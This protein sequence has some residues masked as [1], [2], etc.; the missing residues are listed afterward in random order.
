MRR[1][2]EGY[3]TAQEADTYANRTKVM[4]EA[5]LQGEIKSLI[6]GDP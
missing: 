4:E 5:A 3:M 1:D 6:Q 2:E